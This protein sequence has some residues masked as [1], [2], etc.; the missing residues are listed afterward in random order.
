[1]RRE[2]HVSTSR[3]SKSHVVDRHP[4]AEPQEGHAPT[5]LCEIPQR[6]SR[7]TDAL[8]S[9]HP[10]SSLRISTSF[11][12]T[13]N[14]IPSLPYRH[15]A[16]VSESSSTHP[17]V[18]SRF[19]SYVC[20]WRAA[21]YNRMATFSDSISTFAIG[22]RHHITGWQHSTIPSLRLQLVSGVMVAE[23]RQHSTIPFLRLQLAG[24]HV[25]IRKR[26][27]T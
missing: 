18:R 9:K 4:F 6:S 16:L 8:L 7:T 20:N 5:A 1:M 2:G 12:T 14:D 17:V 23:F 26:Y 24:W 11:S 25:C 27:A 15:P 3:P 10:P 21:S 19:Y 13:H 22:G